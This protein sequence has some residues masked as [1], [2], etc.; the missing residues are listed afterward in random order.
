MATTAPTIFP[1]ISE[2]DLLLK[3]AVEAGASLEALAKGAVQFSRR[4]TLQELQERWHSLLYDSDIAE[5]ASVRMIELELKANRPEY[6]KEKKEVP[7][8]RKLKT[9]HKQYHALRKKFRNDF[10]NS[11]D[12]CFLEGPSLQDFSG[13]ENV[14]HDRNVLGNCISDNLRFQEAELDILRN[15]FPEALAEIASTSCI[16]YQTG[17]SNTA[18]DNQVTEASRN[19]VFSEG[20]SAS[21][22]ERATCIQP[23]NEL[24][25]VP[26]VPKDTPLNYGK[27]SVGEGCC[28]P[29]A[30]SDGEFTDLPDS[31]LNLS[32]DDDILMEDED[33]RN[34]LDNSS[35]KNGILINSSDCIQESGAYTHESET[36]IDSKTSPLPPDGAECI[37]SEMVAPST[38]DQE[39]TCY[40]ETIASTNLT[41]NAETNKSTDGSICC[42]LNTEDTEIPCNDDIFLLIHPSTSFGSAVTEPRSAHY[43]DTP[44]VANTKD[45]KQSMNSVTRG[46]CYVPSLAWSHK[47][48]HN[49]LGEP[50]IQHSAKSKL[51]ETTR[52][53]LLSGEP[54][55]VLSDSRQG[56]T[57]QGILEAPLGRLQE[58]G[59]AIT[60]LVG[61]ASDAHPG[62]PQFSE[63]GCVDVA[64]VELS[65]HPSTSDQEEPT[66]D[67]D[68]PYFSDI[69]A[70]ILDMDLDPSD[71]DSY[72][73][74]QLIRYHPEDSKKTI[75][76]LEQCALS[77]MHRAMSSQGAFA[78][79][80]GRHLRYFIKKTKVILGRSTD[81]IDVDVDLRKEGNANKISRRQA[82]IR[83]E[84]D[85]SF[86]LRN[87]GKSSITVNGKTVDNGKM[88]LLS[89]SCL[90]EIK[91]MGFVFEMN[92]K[93]VQRHLDTQKDKAKFG[94][95]DWSSEG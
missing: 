49:I 66:S 53:P 59:A 32:N 73:A 58:Q 50:H 87:I 94:K 95:F 43:L 39:I 51:T 88:Q 24:C 67:D 7:R 85:G 89:S 30:T 61:D 25:E 71:Q 76:R 22:K 86:F 63:Q 23:S 34:I 37:D 77:S 28:L 44:S 79:L 90:I 2:D 83:M 12:L 46:K 57:L 20:F 36:L 19:I 78:I 72:T 92:R 17:C 21:L 48:G 65:V 41:S 38:C 1:W 75:I 68:V 8:K 14:P 47:I 60:G 9:I 18:G 26:H 64:A 69:E 93:Y 29:S 70:M 4:Y 10:F 11:T 15:A 31:L 5:Q 33:V 27:C 52:P 74:T 54:N 80:Y 6:I 81:D 91:G 35:D 55:K 3:N 40:R 82:I 16:A 13:H 84:P 45:T 62:M 56:R 42:T